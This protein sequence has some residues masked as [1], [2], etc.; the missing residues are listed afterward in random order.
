MCDEFL[1][2]GLDDPERLTSEVLED[3]YVGQA[4]PLAVSGKFPEQP[5]LKPQSGGE[6]WMNELGAS[7]C[8]N[9]M[10]DIPQCSEM[11]LDALEVLKDDGER[12]CFICLPPEP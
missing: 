5:V 6:S 3:D 10:E 8:L 4:S 2:E 12:D 7:L 9:E 1:L 11:Y